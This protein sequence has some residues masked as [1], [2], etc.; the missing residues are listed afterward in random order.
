M[1]G[2]TLGTL[3]WRHDVRNHSSHN[4]GS[5]LFGVFLLNSA[6]ASCII[7]HIQFCGVI[8]SGSNASHGTDSVMSYLLF[9]YTLFV[10]CVVFIYSFCAR[11][12]ISPPLAVKNE[13]QAVLATPSSS[14][15]LS[16]VPF[17]SV[18]CFPFICHFHLWSGEKGKT[19]PFYTH[20][21][22]Q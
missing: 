5:V 17:I 6:F 3:A 10:A 13:A 9:V 14:L 12:P 15:L 20:G 21:Q 11:F 19:T 1:L 2:R 18:L 22:M 7:H 16:C 8:A 4:A